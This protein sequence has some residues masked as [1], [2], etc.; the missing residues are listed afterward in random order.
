MPWLKLDIF[1]PH[2]LTQRN[3]LRLIDA[4]R[5]SN[6]LTFDKRIKY[7]KRIFFASKTP[8]FEANIYCE[9]QMGCLQQLQT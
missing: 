5:F 6:V 1:L 4:I 8:I 2:V 3:L 9:R 7:D